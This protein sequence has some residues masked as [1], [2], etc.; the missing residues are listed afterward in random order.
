M[1]TLLQN[2]LILYGLRMIL[3]TAVFY[4]YYQA[5]LRNR[6]F[7]V[8]NRWFLLG[9][10]LLS[11]L[12]P[13]IRIPMHF[14]WTNTGRP[15][16]VIAAVFWADNDSSGT[17]ALY[18]PATDPAPPVALWVL[19]G[20]YGLIT[21]LLLTRLTRS[22]YRITR[23]ARKYPATPIGPI[24]LLKTTETGAPFSFLNWLFWDEQTDPSGIPGHLLFLHESYHIR[25]RHTLDILGV[26]IIRSLCWFNPFFHWALQEL[27]VLHEFGA[28]QYAL[29]SGE[30]NEQRHRYA[31]LLVWQS[32]GLSR[33]PAITHSFFHN[34]LKRRV[35]MITQITQKPSGPLARIMALPLLAI[36]LGIFATAP[37]QEVQHSKNVAS[38]SDSA[39]LLRLYC[40]TLRY[41]DQVVNTGQGGTVWF[42]VKLG[43]GGELL[44]YT[45]YVTAPEGQRLFR[46]DVHGYA[47][48]QAPP[49]T[50]EETRRLLQA[51]TRRASENI[52]KKNPP[53]PSTATTTLSPGE[54]YFE[55]SYKVEKRKN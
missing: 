26:E 51:E 2:H 28:D 44:E 40:K 23:T 18:P 8:Y 46:I 49:L 50:K 17:G 20:I 6:S 25:Q 52:G 37:A 31:E 41:P 47:G 43:E 3:I 22:V 38:L 32:V 14:T 11:L 27:K 9:S 36:L 1:N 54:Y 4:G 53:A 13:L 7:H 45:P 48:H 33:P 29:S 21:A 30:N 24:R 10:V 15:A 55:V 5:F 42:S 16:G 19:I 12:L 35:T 34:Q 39:R